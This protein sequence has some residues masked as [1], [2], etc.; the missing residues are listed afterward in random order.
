MYNLQ[1]LE[2]SQYFVKIMMEL[3]WTNC[4]IENITHV[5]LHTNIYIYIS[6]ILAP[7]DHDLMSAMMN[8]IS[9]LEQRVT[10]QDKEI[11]EK[12]CT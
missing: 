12:V 3:Y 2:S 7:N 9:L 5:T 4:G 8:R 6:F 10:S 1:L 11:T